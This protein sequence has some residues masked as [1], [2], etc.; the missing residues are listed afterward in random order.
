MAYGLVRSVP[1]I[2]TLGRPINARN[3]P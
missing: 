1:A 2:F 3:M